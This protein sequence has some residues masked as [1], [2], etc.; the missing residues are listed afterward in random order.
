MNFDGGLGM[1]MQSH[2]TPLV[3]TL[4]GAVLL[5]LLALVGIGRLIRKEVRAGGARGAAWRGPDCAGRHLPHVLLPPP[6][7]LL[8]PQE[9]G[10]GGGGGGRGGGFG[11]GWCQ[12]KAHAVEGPQRREEQGQGWE[13]EG[14]LRVERERLAT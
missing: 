3:A 12:S 1:K 4:M 10:G 7:L 2:L 13:G 8:L 5:Q 9:E 11:L 14:A 6:V